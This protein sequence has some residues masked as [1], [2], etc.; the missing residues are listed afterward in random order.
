MKTLEQIIGDAAQAAR[1]AALA[2]W[3]RDEHQ[4]RG[5]CGGA[6][7]L[8]KAGRKLTKAALELGVATKAGKDIFVNRLVPAEV[9]KSQNADIDQAAARAFRQVLLD[10]GCGDAIKKFWTYID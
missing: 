5:S 3:E 8:L 6:V 2:V 1:S 10:N 7:L 4:D 9:V